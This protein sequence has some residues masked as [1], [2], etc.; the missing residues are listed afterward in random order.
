MFEVIQVFFEFAQH[1][2]VIEK[3]V[4][5][6]SA[7]PQVQVILDDVLLHLQVV[8]QLRHHSLDVV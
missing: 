4:S 6:I 8:L 3:V 5:V 1:E 2:E 7:L